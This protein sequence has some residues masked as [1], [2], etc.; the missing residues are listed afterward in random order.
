M[1]HVPPPCIIENIDKSILVDKARDTIL[2]LR[3][4]DKQPKFFIFLPDMMIIAF[5]D[6]YTMVYALKYTIS[7]GKPSLRG[8]ICV[9]REHKDPYVQ[10]AEGISID[11][12]TLNNRIIT[13]LVFKIYGE[14]RLYYYDG[15]Y[16]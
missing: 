4:S 7:S 6:D 2:K 12:T 14:T 10:I 16:G 5:T 11:M 13:P 15:S 3:H 8:A 1:D 9:Y